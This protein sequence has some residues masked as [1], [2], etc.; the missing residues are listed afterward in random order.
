MDT[1]SDAD[2]LMTTLR[3]STRAAL[4]TIRL[5]DLTDVTQDDLVEFSEFS[6]LTVTQRAWLLAQID[7]RN[8]VLPKDIF[9]ALDDCLPDARSMA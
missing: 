2:A 7:A 6:G 1:R 4:R 9:Q 3:S 8:A 5:R